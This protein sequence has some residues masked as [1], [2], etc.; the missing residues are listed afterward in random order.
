M[1]MSASA[2]VT[3]IT[4]T[5]T[6]ILVLTTSGAERKGEKDHNHHGNATTTTPS[7]ADTNGLPPGMAVQ[8]DPPLSPTAE[9]VLL[10]AGIIGINS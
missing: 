6:E 1:T 3:S 7:L 4:A 10:A 2:V 8:K 9:H 5:T